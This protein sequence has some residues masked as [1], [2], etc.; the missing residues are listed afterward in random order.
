M[1]KLVQ[2]L[3][4]IFSAIA[5]GVAVYYFVQTRSAAAEANRPLTMRKVVLGEDESKAA[6]ET[7]ADREASMNRIAALP[8]EVMLDVVSVNLD[9]DEGEEQILTVR[10]TDRSGDRLSIVVA[11]YVPSRR[12][13]ARAW[14][15]ATLA[16]KLTTFQIQTEDLAGDHSLDIICTGMD[17]ANEQTMAVFRRMGGSDDS[18]MSF[19][20]IAAIA[21]DSIV[22][23]QVERSEGYQLGQTRGASWPIF[24][25]RH[26]KDSPN[27][28]DQVK[29]IYTWDQRS[30]AYMVTGTERIPGAQV[31][32]EAAN[33]LLTGK[34]EDFEHFLQGAWVES[35]KD[36]RDSTARLLVFDRSQNSIIFYAPEEQ[37]DFDWSESHSTRYGLYVSCVNESVSDLRRLMD[38]ELTGADAI[39][40]R[41]F[42][43]LKMKVDPQ[44][45]WDGTYRK[46]DAPKDSGRAKP[47]AA[48]K[49]EGSW[50]GQ[51]G[52]I[53]SFEGQR[54]TLDRGGKQRRG[55]YVVFSLSGE[56][57]LQLTY[58][59]DTGIQ[60]DREIWRLRYSEAKTGSTT[61]R[62]IRLS[63]ARVAIEGIELLEEPELVLDRR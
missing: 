47:P 50:K 18:P 51:D 41:I 19:S 5:L 61:N 35:G 25:Y 27:L 36:S 54:F 43:D 22:V 49:A 42:E 58:L 33:R 4:I 59:S 34:E 3:F 10:K 2:A 53:L 21:A 62:R 40:V 9:Q 48:F 13:W 37:E 12:G 6:A 38:I 63:P 23:S 7:K 30:G 20:P 16:T 60:A 31:E 45:S 55:G 24:A 26:D 56:T 1:K 29:T 11:D 28:L 44:G 17:D 46:I 32:K 8:N 52:T 57:V 15:G 39:S 14:E